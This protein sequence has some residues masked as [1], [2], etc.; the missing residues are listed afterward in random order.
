M[1]TSI[2]HSMPSNVGAADSPPQFDQPQFEGG[3]FSMSEKPDWVEKRQSTR[4]RAEQLLAR[5]SVADASAQPAEV[6]A[7]ELLVHKVELEMQVEEL[8]QAHV[9]MEESRDRYVDLHDFAP[10]GYITVSRE[11]LISEI[12]LTGAAMLGIERKKLLNDRFSKFISARD[13]DRWHLLFVSLMKQAGNARQ[14]LALGIQ[15]ADA[16]AFPAY[17]DCCRREGPDMNAPPHLRLMLVD[18]DRIKQAE[19]E[20]HNAATPASGGG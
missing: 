3:N 6:L 1:V 7:H 11:G 2:C 16:S 14:A 20:M 13:A 4:R 8:R 10:V 18:I 9:A 5:L 17:L 19:A 15:R 12:N